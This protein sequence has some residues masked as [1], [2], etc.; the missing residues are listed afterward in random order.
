M[1][2]IVEGQISE[3]TNSLRTL[4]WSSISFHHLMISSCEQRFCPY[5]TVYNN[6]DSRVYSNQ[7]PREFFSAFPHP[8][9]AQ[10][11]FRYF[12]SNDNRRVASGEA[13][14]NFVGFPPPYLYIAPAEVSADS[15]KRVEA[16]EPVPFEMTKRFQ[17]DCSTGQQYPSGAE[18]NPLEVEEDAASPTIDWSKKR[19]WPVMGFGKLDIRDNEEKYIISL[20]IPGVTKE[21]I[22][23]SLRP[24]CI[25]VECVRKPIPM[26]AGRFH[27]CE[28]PTGK[29]VRR[30]QLPSQ[31]NPDAIACIYKDGVLTLTVQKI[32][33]DSNVMKI[34][35]D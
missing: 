24:T 5:Q 27:Y 4:V 17:K 1:S 9:P 13:P 35:V 3:E 19:I 32:K 30:I 10:A 18:Q 2:R 11:G 20:D 33:N 22:D 14:P 26:T 15:R 28:R 25:V 21:C 34:P 6:P 31:A 8:L 7:C 12:H 29:L 16:T 23:V